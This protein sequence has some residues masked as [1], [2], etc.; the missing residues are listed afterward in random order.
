MYEAGQNPAY[1]PSGPFITASLPQ[2]TASG[3]CNQ[4]LHDAPTHKADVQGQASSLPSSSSHSA[5]LPRF[6][7]G[8]E[9]YTNYLL[10]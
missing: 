4:S 3:Y 7:D 5:H 10:Y 2:K 1:R 6:H 9:E 8:N